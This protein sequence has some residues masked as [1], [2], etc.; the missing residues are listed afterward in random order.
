[1]HRVFGTKE[2]V[3]YLDRKGA[4]LIPFKENLVGVIQTA[5]GYFLLGGGIE[6]EESDETCIT[7]ECLEETGYTIR[8]YEKI[9]SAEMY[10]TH[11]SIGYFHPIQTYY[12]GELLENVCQPI[13]NDH[14]LRFIAYEDICGHMFS[15]MQNW[16]LEQCRAFIKNV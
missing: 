6:G 10:T 15:P 1:M 7:R 9:A 14:Q 12:I 13:E 3:H 5:K 16:A 4:Y 11:P 8:I 2:N